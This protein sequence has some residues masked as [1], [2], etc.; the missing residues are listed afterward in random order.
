MPFV[1]AMRDLLGAPGAPRA[2]AAARHA[3]G[4]LPR[5]Q[6]LFFYLSGARRRQLHAQR[7]KTH[8]GAAHRLF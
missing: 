5:Q 4:Q 2:R 3:A 1:C 7:V 6:L 8:R